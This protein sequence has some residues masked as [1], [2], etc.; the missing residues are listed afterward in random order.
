MRSFP[1]LLYGALWI[2]YIANAK[3]QVIDLISFLLT[4]QEIFYTYISST[5]IAKQFT[6]IF[7]SFFYKKQRSIIYKDVYLQLRI[8]YFQTNN[9][10]R[11]FNW[12]MNLH[13]QYPLLAKKG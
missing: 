10:K 1:N 11:R 8:S 4:I 12:S 3:R 6:A 7:R 13:L 2:E 9:C 5:I